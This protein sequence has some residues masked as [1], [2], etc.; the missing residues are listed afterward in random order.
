MNLSKFLTLFFAAA[1]VLTSCSSDDDAPPPVSPE[2][3]ITTMI[4]TLTDGTDQV[5]LRFFD[6][7]GADGPTEPIGTV[8]GALKA[9]T[10]YT[11]SISILNETEDPAENVNEEIQEEADEHQFFYIPTNLGVS[12]TYTDKESDYENADGV[13]FT[14]ENPVGLT[15]SI[16]TTADTG[17]G[18]L[19][20]VLRHEP[21]KDAAG[22]SGG[23]ITNAGGDP[24]V[25]WTFN[26][27]VE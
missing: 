8:S 26:V 18:M 25:D 4:V 9:S 13:Q 16:T 22:V 27:S 23:D 15:F 7:D 19:R 14:S 20:F 21:N 12:T 3:V 1:L 10:T 11:G 5:E 24:D 6:E 17:D 2:E